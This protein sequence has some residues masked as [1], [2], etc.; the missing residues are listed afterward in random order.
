MFEA[1]AD[2]LHPG[3][4]AHSY[5]LADPVA[6]LIIVQGGWWYRA[7]LRVV[8]DD[9]GS[10]V[11]ETIVNVAQRTSW[12][13]PIAGRRVIADASDAFERLMTQLRQQLE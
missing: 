9:T 2:R 10:R 3:A 7:E 11:E 1:L 13:A 4:D 12:A 6:S 5:Y 8:P